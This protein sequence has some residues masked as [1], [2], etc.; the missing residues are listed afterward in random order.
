M[1]L[2]KSGCKDSFYN[3]AATNFFAKNFPVKSK[4]LPAKK[5]NGSKRI[6]ARP[7]KDRSNIYPRYGNDFYGF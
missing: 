4:L 3:F 7:L 1:L 5:N 2:F 6:F